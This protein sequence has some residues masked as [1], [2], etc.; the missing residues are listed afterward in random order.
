MCASRHLWT[1][2]LLF[3]MTTRK[4]PPRSMVGHLPLEQAIGVRIPGG[5]PADSKWVRLIPAF[6]E[7]PEYDVNM[8]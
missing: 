5:Q 2:R 3:A 8:T 1:T 7:K 4:V 6:P